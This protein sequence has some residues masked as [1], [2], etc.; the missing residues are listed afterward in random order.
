M[1]IVLIYTYTGI[2]TSTCTYVY[3]YTSIYTY[4]YTYVYM[5]TYMYIF[6]ADAHCCIR[7]GLAIVLRIQM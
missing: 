2:Y 3:I 6:F 7:S 4:V 5:Y 1:D